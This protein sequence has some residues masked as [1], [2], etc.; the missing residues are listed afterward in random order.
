MKSRFHYRY[1]IIE[2]PFIYDQKSETA[3]K[4]AREVFFQMAFR[5]S[6]HRRDRRLVHICDADIRQNSAF[7]IPDECEGCGGGKGATFL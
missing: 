2:I 1:S 7:D 4:F 3:L 6:H 5:F